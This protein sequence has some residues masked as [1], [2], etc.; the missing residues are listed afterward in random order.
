[1]ILDYDPELAA[2]DTRRVGELGPNLSCILARVEFDGLCL[3]RIQ[4]HDRFYELFRFLG[5]GPAAALSLYLLH[6]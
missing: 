3:S 5:T 1:M 2:G 6:L 4:R